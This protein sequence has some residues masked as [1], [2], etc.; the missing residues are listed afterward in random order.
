MSPSNPVRDTVHVVAARSGAGSMP[1]SCR[2]SQTVD[3]AT[4]VPSVSS[5]PCTLRYPQLPFSLARRSA[6]A[7]IE[8]SVRGRPRRRGRDLV[9]WR[10]AIKSRC[11][12]SIVSGRTSSRRRRRVG[13]GSGCS[14][15]ASHARSTGSNL[16]FTDPDDPNAVYAETLTGARYCE[17]PA[18]LAEY[19]RIFTSTY[20]LSVPISDY[21]L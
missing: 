2:I 16:D 18:E 6:K 11:H 19:R 13:L 21:R 12:V 9:A 10:R 17:L 3:G 7:R 15:A 4:R 1:A 20:A 8:R 14:S 5:S